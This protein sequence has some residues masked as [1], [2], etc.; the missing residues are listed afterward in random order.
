[1]T[2]KCSNCGFTKNSHGRKKFF[3]K[4]NINMIFVDKIGLKP[5]EK[6]IPSEGNFVKALDSSVKKLL[7]LKE[8]K[9]CLGI[10]K[11]GIKCGYGDACED[12][13]KRLKGWIKEWKKEK[14]GC[15]TINHTPN[16]LCP[17]CS[18][19]EGLNDS[20][21]EKDNLFEMLPSD[22]QSPQ[23][24][25]LSKDNSSGGLASELA[26]GDITLSSKEKIMLTNEGKQEGCYPSKDVKDFIAKLKA[27]GKHIHIGNN[28]T[29]KIVLSIK[30]INS[31]AGSKLLK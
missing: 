12:C 17:S 30:E 23:T 5:C 19:S 29:D 24:S 31:L 2:S 16:G 20:T 7:K 3:K 15:G 14:K 10:S 27:K 9:G 4:Q 1:M 21:L 26:S 8:K 18:K 25:T 22:N 13:K 6:F 11:S 28:K